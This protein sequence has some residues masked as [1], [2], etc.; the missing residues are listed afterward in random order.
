MPEQG[1]FNLGLRLWYDWPNGA[2][3]VKIDYEGNWWIYDEL[4]QTDLHLDQLVY[5][6]RD[7]MGDD[8]FTRIL[9][10]SAARFELESLRKRKF[11]ITG[12]KK[13]LT[14]STTV[15]KSYAHTWKSEKA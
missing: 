2:L 3:F 11:R 4:Y 8:R 5:I 10:D 15:S 12:A 7:K 1:Q 9:G 14:Q 13:V 6:L